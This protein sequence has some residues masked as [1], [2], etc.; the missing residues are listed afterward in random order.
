MLWIVS[1]K[2]AKLAQSCDDSHRL[3]V[4]FAKF[5]EIFIAP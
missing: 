1:S 4:S 5:G 3:F 2:D